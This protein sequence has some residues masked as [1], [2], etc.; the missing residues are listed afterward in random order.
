VNDIVRPITPDGLVGYDQFGQLIAKRAGPRVTSLHMIADVRRLTCAICER[1]W[2]PSAESMLNQVPWHAVNNDIVHETCLVR[3]CALVERTEF[4]YALIDARVR[5]RRL[6]PEPN[7]YYPEG[8]PWAKKPWYSAELTEHPARF[9]I[10]W[11]KRVV[12][13][14]LQAEGGVPFDWWERAEQAFAEESV[15]KAFGE[16]RVFLHA[17]GMNRVREYAARLTE[18]AGYQYK[19]GV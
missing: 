12:H 7:R 11:R 10:G 6:E 18:I 3:H 8:D 15:T 13:V 9:F 5:F 4:R 19:D 17:Y 1:G 2:E 14:E 16:E